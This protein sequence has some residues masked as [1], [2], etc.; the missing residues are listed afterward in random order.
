MGEESEALR[1]EEI[2]AVAGGKKFESLPG[3][4]PYDNSGVVLHCPDCKG[5]DLEV[6]KFLTFRRF[7][8]KACG[9]KFDEDEC[10]YTISGEF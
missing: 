3:W 1:D 2:E 10:G 6:F 5:T 8:C 7:K 4:D 9:R